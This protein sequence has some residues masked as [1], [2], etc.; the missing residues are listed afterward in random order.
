MT[1]E[2][3]NNLFNNVTEI[4]KVAYKNIEYKSNSL[5]KVNPEI[6]KSE[7]RIENTLKED[8]NKTTP[9]ELPFSPPSFDQVNN[10]NK[11]KVNWADM[12][13]N[14]GMLFETKIYH[15]TTIEFEPLSNIHV[16][17]LSSFAE[18]SDEEEEEEDIDKVSNFINVNK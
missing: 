3:Y 16:P 2:E 4:K 9:F 6:D 18:C 8:I 1:T 13:P 15:P 14:N 11:K 10:T 12:N 17:N 5:K 7:K